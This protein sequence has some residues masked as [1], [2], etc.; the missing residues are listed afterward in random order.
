MSL[1][2]PSWSNP[3]VRPQ[4]TL[5]RMSPPRPNRATIPQLALGP[6]HDGT[7]RITEFGGETFPPMPISFWRIT[8]WPTL[9]GALPLSDLR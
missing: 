2:Y 6:L 7:N 9:A 1:T 3:Y 4:P 5:R 8:T